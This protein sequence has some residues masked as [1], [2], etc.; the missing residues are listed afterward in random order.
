[1][2][3]SQCGKH[4]THQPLALQQRFRERQRDRL[5]EKEQTSQVRALNTSRLLHSGPQL[6]LMMSWQLA[7]G[8]TPKSA[9]E[10]M[11]S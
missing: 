7:S 11:P 4:L 2:T 5:Q 3:S 9:I 8:S 1:M 10:Q 6:Q